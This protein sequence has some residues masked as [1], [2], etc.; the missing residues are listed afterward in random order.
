MTNFYGCLYLNFDP[1]AICYYTQL[2]ICYYVL[3]GA[4]Q[5][6]HVK[7]GGFPLQLLRILDVHPERLFVP[8]L[9]LMQYGFYKMSCLKP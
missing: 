6:N 4:K 9:V 2:T 8:Q 3:E 5:L 7:R 1:V